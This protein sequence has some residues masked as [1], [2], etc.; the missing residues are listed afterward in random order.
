M[1]KVVS[2]YQVQWVISIKP[3]SD[4]PFFSI[5]GNG[6]KVAIF[7]QC[8]TWEQAERIRPIAEKQLKQFPK[9]PYEQIV[10]L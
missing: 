6:S 1:G 9:L 3:D 2:I 8:H 7:I 10:N 4:Q 5:D